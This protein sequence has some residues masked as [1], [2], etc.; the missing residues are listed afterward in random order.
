MSNTAACI[1]LM[2]SHSEISQARLDLR[3]SAKSNKPARYHFD[4]VAEAKE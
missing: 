3:P 2:E 1:R 4:F